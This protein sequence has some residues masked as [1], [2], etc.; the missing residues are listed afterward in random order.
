MELSIVIPVWNEEENVSKLH[1]EIKKSIKTKTNY[2]I[3]F[4]DDGSSDKT[5]SELKKL[6]RT[7]SKIRIIKMRQ[8]VGKSAALSEGFKNAKGKF[9]I[10]M[11][12]DLQDDPA[13][14][15]K[16]IKHIK[17]YDLDLVVGWKHKRQDPITKRWPSKIF[18]KLT[19][20]LTGVKIHDSN[21]CF[22]IYRNEVV[23]NIN[24]YG[25][26]H[27]YIPALAHWKGFKVGEMKVNHKPRRYGKSKYGIMRLL[28]GFLDLISVK[29][30]ISYSKKPM[31]LFGSIG[32]ISLLIG[33][34]VNL[35]LLLLKILYNATIGD[36]PLLMLGILLMVL[37][38]Q[39]I[40]LGL[41][42]ELIIHVNSE[43][44]Q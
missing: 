23:K 40:S 24:V 42:G 6:K 8:H 25:E 17:K 28:I 32:V 3:L 12:G 38:V 37:G 14:I 19:A 21:C 15:P 30:I 18:N 33:F 4:V 13:E 29:F 41:I 22:K 10:T 39:F 5:Y 7:D 36:R 31:H 34:L 16:F 44:R 26:L 27:R 20:W 35:Y 11:D 1:K 43:K 2:E 9:I